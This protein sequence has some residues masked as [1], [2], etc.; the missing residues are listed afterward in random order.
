MTINDHRGT[1]GLDSLA[2]L[3]SLPPALILDQ[4]AFCDPFPLFGI[5]NDDS[6]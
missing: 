5:G 6:A 3:E 4:L 2:S 1:S